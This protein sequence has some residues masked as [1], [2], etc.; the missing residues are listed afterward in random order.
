MKFSRVSTTFVLLCLIELPVLA[1]GKYDYLNKYDPAPR[2][3]T[4]EKAP[5]KSVSEPPLRQDLSAYYDA[6]Q[7]EDE[8]KIFYGWGYQS[9]T[10]NKEVDFYSMLKE[11]ATQE[12]L[13][14][15]NWSLSRDKRVIRFVDDETDLPYSITLGHERNDFARSF[16]DHNIVM[17]HGHSRY[18]RGPAFESFFNYFRMGDVFPTIEVDTRNPY[19]QDEP[20]QLT[21]QYPAQSVTFGGKTYEYQYVGQKTE[22]SYLPENSY[23]KNIPGM[24]V[25]FQKAKFYNGKQLFYLYSCSNI[26]YF[27]NPIRQHFPDPSDRFVFGTKT[28]GMWSEKPAAIFIMSVVAGVKSGDEVTKRLNDTNDCNGCFTTY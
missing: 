10:G 9:Y 24:D 17:Y 16:A 22:S 21:D 1:V 12:G 3:W 11:L 4:V 8:V 15:S 20:M 19:F 18:G 27:K 7:K 5:A 14:I 28:E 13:R 26:N 23:T 2:E 6:F 25:D